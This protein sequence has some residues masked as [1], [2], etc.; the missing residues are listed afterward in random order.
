MRCTKTVPG[1]F[2]RT[3]TVTACSDSSY[4]MS[5]CS[6][7]YLTATVIFND[8]SSSNE[9]NCTSPTFQSSCGTG[10]TVTSWVVK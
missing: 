3:L 6:S 5:G 4:T 9:D 10:E 7:P 8:V 2:T 1:T